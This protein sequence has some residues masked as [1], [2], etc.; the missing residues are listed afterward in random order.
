MDLNATTA[1]PKVAG[2]ELQTFAGLYHTLQTATVAALIF[3]VCASIPKLKHRAQL[4]KLPTLGPDG[5][6]K[7]G[8]GYLKS[9]KYVYSEGYQKFKNCV[10]RITTSDGEDNVVIPPI[11]LP[12]L[13]KL[14][15]DVL[16]FPKAV[17]RSMETKYTKIIT[18]AKLSAHTIKSDLTPALTRLNPM[19]CGEVDAAIRQYLPPCSDWTE[20]R[21]DSTLVDIVARVSGRVFV[22]PDLCQDPEYLE[23]GSKYTI[24]VMQAVHAIKPIRPWLRPFLVPRL[25][26]I[27]RLRDMEKRAAKHL[28]P[29]IRERVEAEKNDPNWQKPDDMLQWLM[30]RSAED[31]IF[32]IGEMA[33]LQL[34]LIFAAIHTT[35]MTATNILYTLAVTP[36]YIKHLRE[37][38]QNASVENNGIITSRAL[39]QMEKLDSY[40][41]EVTRLWPPGITSFGRRVLKGITL[42]NGQYI[43]PGVIIEVPSQAVYADSEHYPDSETF[44]GFRHY[45]LRRG[46]TA[47]D[48][49][50]HQFV[51]TNDTN[52]TFGYGRHACPGRFF[53]ANE[54]KMILARL[55]LEFDIK[56]PGDATERYKQM[57]F[58]RTT[59]PSPGKTIMLKRVAA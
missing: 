57:E 53:A 6:G 46:G 28:Q 14:P 22:G 56:M 24:F 42:S 48:H 35:T 21:M 9:A 8:Q 29:I 59:A 30:T 3:L 11:L 10:F 36:E 31:G 52:L 26:E 17:D 12:E 25:P 33:K 58:G 19:I 27:Q 4:A 41:K 55:I 15:D 13:R 16:S 39:Q 45:K 50:R 23:C 34:G 40:M 37:E 38:I 49:A 43:P 18:D 44:D 1:S 7:Q 20:V 32:T 5:G 54:I 51:T 47:T 2:I